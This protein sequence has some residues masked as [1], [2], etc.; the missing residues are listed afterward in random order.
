MTAGVVHDPELR[1]LR[2]QADEV[3]HPLTQRGHVVHELVEL[4]LEVLGLE[5]HPPGSRGVGFG[6]RERVE[7]LSQ[8]PAQPCL[9][10]HHGHGMRALRRNVSRGWEIGSDLPRV[11]AMVHDTIGSLPLALA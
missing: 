4:L 3:L 11:E 1:V 5:E 10:L 6:R 9:P 8:A 2:H 7:H